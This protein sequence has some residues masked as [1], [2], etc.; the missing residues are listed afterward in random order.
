MG[1]KEMDPRPL[2]SRVVGKRG[3][4]TLLYEDLC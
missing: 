3:L 2:H 4:H 1:Q